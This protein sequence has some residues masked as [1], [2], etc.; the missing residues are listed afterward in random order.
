M[1]T[2]SPTSCD[3]YKNVD[4]EDGWLFAIIC[5]EFHSIFQSVVLLFDAKSLN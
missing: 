3:V 4:K 2:W 5:E 1:E